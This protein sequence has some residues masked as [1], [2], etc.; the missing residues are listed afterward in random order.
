ML[1]F[2]SCF[3]GWTL[4]KRKLHKA[5]VCLALFEAC[6]SACGAR[7]RCPFL[8]KAHLQGRK[9]P[10]Q[11]VGQDL[12]SL[13]PRFFS[14]LVVPAKLLCIVVTLWQRL[15]I[16]V[17]DQFLRFPISVLSFSFRPFFQKGS[18]SWTRS[19]CGGL[20]QARAQYAALDAWVPVKARNLCGEKKL[21]SQNDPTKTPDFDNETPGFQFPEF[22]S[23]SHTLCLKSELSQVFELI[24]APNRG[25][26]ENK[27][28][29]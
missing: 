19:F 7:D 10:G 5:L 16:G 9:V 15:E 17:E 22:G 24:E 27:N 18:L 20:C 28:A 2:W 26:P 25:Y 4:A 6:F 23:T 21:E 29:S 13:K 8:D 12:P 11:T 3:W 14:K 1:I